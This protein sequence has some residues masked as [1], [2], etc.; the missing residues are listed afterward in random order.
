MRFQ[1][2]QK[3]C[4]SMQPGCSAEKKPDTQTVLAKFNEDYRLYQQANCD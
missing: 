1:G 2:V 4:F 3:Y